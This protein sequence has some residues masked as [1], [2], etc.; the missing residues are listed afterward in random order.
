[1]NVV[2][3]NI[4][5][6]GISSAG[7]VGDDLPS[8]L[9]R[10]IGRDVPGSYVEFLEQADGGHPEIGCFHVEG[11]GRKDNLFDV[12][13]FYSVNNPGVESIEGA[14]SLWRETLG[15]SCLPIGRD[16]GGNQIYLEL[17]D[18]VPAVWLYLHD[19]SRVRLKLADSLPIFLD[20][21]ISNPD[22]I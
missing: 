21:L 6:N 22:F 17:G 10:L 18:K 12:D 1:M 16:G 11:D 2:R 13:W 8:K 5:V 4:N 20:S 19:E 7:Y 14:I 9:N 15:S 3:L